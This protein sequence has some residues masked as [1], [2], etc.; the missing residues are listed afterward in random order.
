MVFLPLSSCPSCS[1]LLLLL[2]FFPFVI[3]TSSEIELCFVIFR[4]GGSI[5]FFNNVMFSLLW[6]FDLVVSAIGVVFWGSL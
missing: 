5:D 2:S 6:L 4:N 3:I 1:L